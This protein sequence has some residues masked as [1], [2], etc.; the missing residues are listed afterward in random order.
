M[1]SATYTPSGN[2][3]ATS[4]VLSYVCMASEHE[5]PSKPWTAFEASNSY[6]WNQPFAIVLV[7]ARYGSDAYYFLLIVAMRFQCGHLKSWTV[8]CLHNW[9]L[10]LLTCGIQEALV[11]IWSTIK[12]LII[13]TYLCAIYSLSLHLPMPYLFI[14]RCILDSILIRTPCHGNVIGSLL[15]SSDSIKHDILIIRHRMLMDRYES[16]L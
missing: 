16:L 14:F 1:D 9:Q 11:I 6:E 3:N 10:Y 7:I 13:L 12:Q 5:H 15:E 8:P 4:K 2:G